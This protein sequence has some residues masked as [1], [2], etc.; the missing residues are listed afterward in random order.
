MDL[1]S[2]YQRDLAAILADPALSEAHAALLL[3]LEQGA[4]RAAERDAGGAWHANTWVKTA[5]LAGFRS[6]ATALV[7]GWPSPAFDRTAFP[8][9]GEGGRTS[10]TRYSSPMNATP[11]APAPCMSVCAQLSMNASAGW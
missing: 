1:K 3:A 4:A 7:P 2:F 5:I 11:A 8:P 9:R 10:P 6:T